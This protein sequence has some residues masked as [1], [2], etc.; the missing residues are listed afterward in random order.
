M[1]SIVIPKVIIKVQ[2]QVDLI[3]IKIKKVVKVNQ[4]KIRKHPKKKL[5]MNLK[6]TYI[7]MK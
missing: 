2:E 4:V 1:H 3:L 6:N 5:L 7:Q